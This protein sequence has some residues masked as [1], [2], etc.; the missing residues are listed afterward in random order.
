MVS[1]KPFQ[2]VFNVIQFNKGFY[3]P[4]LAGILVLGMIS[5]FSENAPIRSIA[6]VLWIIGLIPTLASLTITYWIYDLSNVYDLPWLSSSTESLQIAQIHAGFDECTPQLKELFPQAKLFEFDFYNE[7]KQ[8]EPSIKIARAKYPP[9]S[10][11]V[12]IAFDMIPLPDAS[13]DILHL[14]FAAHE[15]RTDAEREI[16]LKECKRILKEDGRIYIIEHWRDGWNFLAY[17][18]GFFHFHSYKTWTRNF[19]NTKLLVEH[20]ENI[21]PF[22]HCF[23]LKK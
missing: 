17:T 22:V 18:I 6:S 11:T 2:G 23:I 9:S 10:E 20:V 12:S 14:M 8:T 7:E 19:R 4:A 1:R 5:F 15:I 3:F 16:F 13:V 21:T